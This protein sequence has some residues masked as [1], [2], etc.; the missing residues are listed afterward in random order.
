VSNEPE[1]AARKREWEEEFTNS[2]GEMSAADRELSDVNLHLAML[3]EAM[4]SKM[5]LG[6]SRDE[7]A[8]SK[9]R[10]TGQLNAIKARLTSITASMKL[11]TRWCQS[12]EVCF[13]VLAFAILPGLAFARYRGRRLRVALGLCAQCGYDLRATP[14]RCPEC[15]SVGGDGAG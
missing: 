9:Q 2:L 11:F 12:S 13:L 8:A 4:S 1:E 3:E 5:A 7:L 15:G 6:P 10:L 14:G